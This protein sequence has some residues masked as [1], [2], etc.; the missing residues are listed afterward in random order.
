MGS[1]VLSIE[2]SSNLADVKEKTN[3]VLENLKETIKDEDIIFDIKTILT[4][5]VVNGVVHGNSM[6]QDKKVYLD[7]TLENDEL[8]ICVRDEGQGFEY[9][10]DS[11]NVFD[12][13]SSGRGLIMVNGL[14]D[15]FNINNNEVFVRKSIRK[16]EI[17]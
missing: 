4:E 1:Q 17:A 15:E 12:M 2:I 5:L 8:L 7:I 14:C 3:L 10:L 11:Y 9:C 6:D 13:K 16:D